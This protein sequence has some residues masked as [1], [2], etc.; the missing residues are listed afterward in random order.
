MRGYGYGSEFRANKLAVI[1]HALVTE[2]VLWRGRYRIH[3]LRRAGLS[4]RTAI[5]RYEYE[6]TIR[7][8]GIRRRANAREGRHRGLSSRP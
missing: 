4:P 5:V 7:V 6:W 8:S 1:V 3:I 2:N